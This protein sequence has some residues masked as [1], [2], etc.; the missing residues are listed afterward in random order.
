MTGVRSNLPTATP[1]RPSGRPSPRMILWL[2]LGG[3]AV[4]FAIRAR[5]DLTAAAHALARARP[6]WVLAGGGLSALFLVNLAA[7]QGRSQVLLGV[8]RRFR[9]TLRLTAGA[10]ALDLATKSGGM[11]GALRFAADARRRG[12][13]AQCT[14]AGCVLTELATHLGFTAVLLVAIPFAVV[15][16]HLTGAD[17]VAVAIY[18]VL[19]AAL[20]VA[21]IAAARSERAI[22]RVT[23]VIEKITNLLRRIG[24]HPNAGRP[25][26]N[27]SADDLHLAI[28]TARRDRDALGPMVV[29]ALMWPLIG[30]AL[31]GSACAAVGAHVSPVTVLI[32]YCLATTFSII[33]F[34]PGGLVFAEV[35][36][37]ATMHGFGVDGGHAVAVIALYRL[38][39]LWIPLIAGAVTLRTGAGVAEEPSI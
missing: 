1:V 26:R 6:L 32:T 18:L 31:L 37:G 21:V 38:F 15:G 8:D 22:Q 30:A 5:T 2:A 12:Q 10:R 24:R 16:A 4:V 3:L 14:T 19:T 11:A 36:L 34:L 28:A 20:L 35:S 17:V 33:G 39:D 23:D 7:L 9:R 13:S 29:H 27:Q 25:A